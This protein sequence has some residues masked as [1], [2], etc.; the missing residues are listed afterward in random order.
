MIW[1]EKHNRSPKDTTMKILIDGWVFALQYRCDRFWGR[2]GN[3]LDDNHWT[4]SIKKKYGKVMI[5]LL[6]VHGDSQLLV[7]CFS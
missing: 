5:S 6:S 1:I 2:G 4:I 7:F 3:T